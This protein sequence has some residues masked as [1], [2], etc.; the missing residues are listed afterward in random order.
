MKNLLS[1]SLEESDFFLI[2][3]VVPDFLVQL[4]IGV[5]S[6]VQ[7]MIGIV[8]LNISRDFGKVC[9]AGFVHKLKSYEI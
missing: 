9:Y 5:V 8:S 4:M 2:L 6:A 7:L 3:D 1:D